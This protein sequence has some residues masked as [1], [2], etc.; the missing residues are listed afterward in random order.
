[1]NQRFHEPCVG[2]HLVVCLRIRDGQPS[3]V[4]ERLKDGDA[5]PLPEMAWF[6]TVSVEHPQ[7]CLLTGDRETDK[8]AI[9]GCGKLRINMW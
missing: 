3:L 9:A 2:S 5:S 4:S 1:M 8:R 6:S 7:V